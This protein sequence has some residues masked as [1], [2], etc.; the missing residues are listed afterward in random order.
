MT[1]EKEVRKKKKKKTIIRGTDVILCVKKCKT[2]PVC[3]KNEEKETIALLPSVEE[4]SIF[5]FVRGWPT[6]LA[7]RNKLQF[8]A[9]VLLKCCH[10]LLPTKEHSRLVAEDEEVWQGNCGNICFFQF[11][12][13]LKAEQMHCRSSKEA[14]SSTASDF[15]ETKSSMMKSW[16]VRG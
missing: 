5:P 14:V 11:S 6:L 2:I 16:T 4:S 10:T 12:L 3:Q 7:S 9:S 15:K 13:F 8:C 1:V